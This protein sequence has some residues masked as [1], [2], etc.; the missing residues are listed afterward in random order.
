MSRTI[1][2]PFM[3]NGCATW[4][5]CMRSGTVQLT[6]SLC[7][8]GAASRSSPGIPCGDAEGESA[9]RALSWSSHGEELRRVRSLRLREA[10]AVQW[11]GHQIEGIPVPDADGRVLAY[12]FGLVVVWIVSAFAL[13]VIVTTGMMQRATN[14]TACG[15][16]SEEAGSP[17][18]QL[19]RDPLPRREAPI[20][21]GGAHRERPRH[22]KGTRLAPAATDALELSPSSTAP[23][24]RWW[25]D[26]RASGA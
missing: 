17:Q 15:T 12:D 18:R 16:D 22:R 25:S 11:C 23:S 13:S 24:S 5:A 6:E 2:P 7:G 19:T 14:P 10:H 4:V 21:D 1:H 9:T 8:D 26:R 20:G 3:W